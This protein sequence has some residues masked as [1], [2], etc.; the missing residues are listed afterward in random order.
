MKN[1]GFTLIELVVV[2][3][4]LGILATTIAPKYIDFTTD[5]HNSNLQGV[6]AAMQG[7][8]EIVHS[9]SLVR[10]NQ[11][12]AVAEAPTII[13]IDGALPIHFGYP[14]ATQAAWQRLLNLDENI[15][16]YQTLDATT[17]VIFLTGSEVPTTVTTPCTVSYQTP[18]AAG[19]LPIYTFTPC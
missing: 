9:K 4:I 19:N 1:Q 6:Q 11:G 12:Q 2:I 10:G 5:A 17:I 3:V 18:N 16:S 15:Y 8:A 13:R 14:V 7:G